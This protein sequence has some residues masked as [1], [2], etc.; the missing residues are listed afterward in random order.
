MLATGAPSSSTMV[1]VACGRASWIPSDAWLRTIENVSVSSSTASSKTGSEIGADVERAGIVTVP[2]VR[3]TS[4]GPAVPATIDQSIETSFGS[5]AEMVT[6]AEPPVP[7]LTVLSAT[8]AV[9]HVAGG[10]HSGSS[11][12]RVRTSEFQPE[13]ETWTT[14]RPGIGISVG[15]ETDES[16]SFAVPTWPKKSQ[17]QPST[18]PSARRTVAWHALSMSISTTGAPAGSGTWTGALADWPPVTPMT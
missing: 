3:S 16:L 10:V 14:R 17:P 15:V 6:V 8:D 12:G 18:V 1:P 11:D 4:S 13:F 2:F 5:G 7:S 9:T